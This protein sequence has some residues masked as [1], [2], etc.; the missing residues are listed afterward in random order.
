MYGSQLLNTFERIQ[1]LGLTDSWKSFSIRW[2]GKGEDLLRDYA[3][4]GGATARV[5]PRTVVRLRE[6]LAEAA[7]LL[8]AD[9][10][11]QVQEI[12]AGIERDLRVAD[13]LGRR[14]AL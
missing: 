1:A 13:L 9:L 6:R 5:S 7:S 3:R 10:A 8:P 14:S 12:D 2:C 11:A 4:R